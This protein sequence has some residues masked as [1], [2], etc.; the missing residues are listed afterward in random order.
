MMRNVLLTIFA[1]V[2]SYTVYQKFFT[3]VNIPK[4][5]RV[6]TAPSVDDS[7]MIEAFEE[8]PT[9]SN[10]APPRH[11]SQ[12]VPTASADHSELPESGEENQPAESA[13]LEA[14]KEKAASAVAPSIKEVR[15]SEAELM[16]SFAADERIQKVAD[17]ISVIC[18]ADYC[19]VKAQAKPNEDENLENQFMMHLK[20]H[21][22]F[23][24]EFKLAPI[25]DA[26]H[27]MTFTYPH[28]PEI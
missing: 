5:E 7:E 24:A 14:P 22:Q 27:M 12:N 20:S 19:E 28:S 23:G 2:L 21:P 26:E 9:P 17:V 4:D 10:F 6:A 8:V 13:P 1:L 25:K 11:P 18:Y 15:Y 3:R 16:E